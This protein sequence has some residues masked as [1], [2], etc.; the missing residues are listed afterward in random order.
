MSSDEVMAMPGEESA[1]AP[2]L[3]E[4]MGTCEITGTTVPEDELIDFQGYRVCA[5]GKAE[6]LQRLKSGETLP[7]E[8]ERPRFLRRF[9]CLFVDGIVIG[10]VGGA[11]SFAFIGGIAFTDPEKLKDVSSAQGMATLLTLLFTVG[12][13]TLMHGKYGQTLGKMAGKIKV[14]NPDGSDITM[15]Q[16]LIRA[17]AY[18][19]PQ[20]LSPFFMLAL[21]F[22]ASQIF[23]MLAGLYVW[24]NLIVMLIDKEMHRA[25]HDRL[26][27]TRVVL[28]D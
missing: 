10:V 20:L 14:V 24:A 11:F 1:Q 9:G 23:T 13:L 7:G 26:A 19:G 16:G 27:K 5:E 22:E 15:G 8:L 18:E 2:P 12:Y 25:I 4:G 21:S 28:K 3:Q 17:L 6:I